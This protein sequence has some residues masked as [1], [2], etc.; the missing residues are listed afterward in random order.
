[1]APKGEVVVT[2]D[3]QCMV[4]LQEERAR[5]S[6][7][8]DEITRL[9]DGGDEKTTQRRRIGEQGVKWAGGWENLGEG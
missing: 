7:N 9:L 8:K 2:A 6:F 1:M 4:D 3:Q 5:C